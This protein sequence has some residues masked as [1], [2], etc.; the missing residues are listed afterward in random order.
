M[1]FPFYA[2]LL[3]WLI[4]HFRRRAGRLL[5]LLAATVA[6]ADSISSRISKPWAARARPCHAPTW[7]PNSICPMAAAGSLASCPPTLPT[8]WGWPCS[9]C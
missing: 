5:L 1:W 9:C 8:R 2:V 6:L 3:G 7:L 4:Y